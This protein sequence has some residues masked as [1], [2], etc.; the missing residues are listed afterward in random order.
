MTK[1]YTIIL[2]LFMLLGNLAQ[3]YNENMVIQAAQKIGIPQNQIKKITG[4]MAKYSVN[5]LNKNYIT[6]VDFSKPSTEHRGFLIQTDTGRTQSFLVSHGKNSGGLYAEHFSNV[7]GSNMSSLGLYYVKQTYSGDNGYSARVSGLE[8]SNSN[9]E[10]RTIVIHPADYV[11]D[12]FIQ[13][14]GM[15]GR[16]EGC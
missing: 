10:V 2:I 12:A 8:A 16:S 9:V 11:S 1:N 6:F 5:I 14:N 13:N 7:M 3:A 15:L 4:Y